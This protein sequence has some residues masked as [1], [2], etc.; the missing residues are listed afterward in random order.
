MEW[1]WSILPM[2]I[3]LFFF[4]RGDIKDWL[5]KRKAQRNLQKQM[6]G[7]Y[8]ASFWEKTYESAAKDLTSNQTHILNRLLSIDDSKCPMPPT[9]EE[10]KAILDSTHAGMETTKLMILE[11]VAAQQTIDD[12]SQVLCLVGPPGT[13]KTTLCRSI[14]HALG[15]DYEIIPMSN[16]CSGWE[17]GGSTLGYEDS[18]VGKILQAILK[19]NSYNIVF[20]F[21]EIDKAAKESHYSNP[22]AALLQL[23]D[24]SKSEF[25]DA[26]LGIPVDLSRAVFICT[27]NDADQVNPILLDRCNVVYIGGYSKDEKIGLLESHILPKLY[28]KFKTTKESISFTSSAVEELAAIGDSTPGVR[29]LQKAAEA[30]FLRANLM[31]KLGRTQV[32]F[33]GKSIKSLI[34]KG[35][36][37]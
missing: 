31:L 12:F 27:A 35:E 23:F 26:Y 19:K 24:D 29:G 30:A 22:E 18:G 6:S 3:I 20:I 37:K 16:L 36:Y 21:D 14:A 13:G 28:E 11:Y 1:L 25:V 33:D 15:R 4:F 9:L 5:I 10:A 7:D 17:L 8:K 2:T 34:P 32:R